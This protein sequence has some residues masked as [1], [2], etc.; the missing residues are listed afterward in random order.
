MSLLARNTGSHVFYRA[1]I[2]MLFTILL[3]GCACLGGSASPPP[4]VYDLAYPSPVL[5]GRQP[6]PDVLRVARFSPVEAL[7]ATAMVT[8]PAARKRDV[9]PSAWWAVHPGFLVTDHLIGDL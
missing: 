6:L 1:F 3:S 4:E 5:A 2:Q 8:S 9:Y 7:T